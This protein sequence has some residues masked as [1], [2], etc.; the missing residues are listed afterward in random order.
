MTNAERE[1]PR[2]VLVVAN[3]ISGRGR[4]LVAAE[5]LLRGFERHGVAAEI[6]RTTAR[7]D[8]PR[9]LAA[10]G[11]ADLVVAIGGDGTLSEVLAGLGDARTPVGLLPMGT[12]NVLAHALA[13]PADPERALASFLGGR[14]QELDVARVGARLAHLV[15]GVGFDAHVVREVEARR[16]GPITKFAYVGAVLR[17]L[18]G[19]RPVPLRVWIDGA[20][21][22]ERPGLVWIA[23]TPKYADLLRFA[24]GTR[25]DDGRWEV[26][27]FARG[28]VPELVTA[29]LRGLVRRLPGG[30]V[31]LRSARHV[32]IEADEPVP[33]QVDGDVGGVTPLAFELLAQRFRIVVP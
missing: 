22:V 28:S 33:Y 31:T 4:G 26:Y 27:L 32:R 14:L 13:L 24:P 20:E 25:L 2:R 21:L 16:R 11:P 3:P 7:G 5:V 18:R 17:M 9:L 19:Y 30:P 1:P 23:N 8:A 12:A 15:V 29:G 10:A 6:L